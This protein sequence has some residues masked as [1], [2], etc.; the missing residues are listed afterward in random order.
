MRGGGRRAAAAWA[1]AAAAAAAL[2]GGAAA[3]AGGG[4]PQGA[5]M[6]QAEMKDLNA[7]PTAD[8]RAQQ[9]DAF[10]QLLGK[11][12]TTF[13]DPRA[14]GWAAREWDPAAAKFACPEGAE[15]AP[16]LSGVELISLLY[17]DFPGLKGSPVD[18]SIESMTRHLG[19]YE[20]SGHQREETMDML[21]LYSAI[22]HQ[23]GTSGDLP[24]DFAAVKEELFKTTFMTPHKSRQAV[25]A[26]S[27]ALQEY[28]LFAETLRYPGYDW[29]PVPGVFGMRDCHVNETLVQYVPDL[30]ARRGGAVAKRREVV[31][32][33]GEAGGWQIDFTDAADGSMAADASDEGGAAGEEA[34]RQALARRGLGLFDGWR[35]AEDDPKLRTVPLLNVE[36]P[37]RLERSA[38]RWARDLAPGEV[39]RSVAHLRAWEGALGRGLSRVALLEDGVAPLA[40][41]W[42]A[43]SEGLYNLDYLQ[44]EWDVIFLETSDWY[45]DAAN[46]NDELGLPPHFTRVAF[47]YGSRALLVSARGLKRLVEHGFGKCVM[48]TDEYLA[49]MSSPGAHPR[50]SEIQACLGLSNPPS[51]FVALRWRGRKVVDDAEKVLQSQISG[52][53]EAQEAAAG[54]AG[55][56]AAPQK[57]DGEL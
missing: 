21:A 40:G 6:T 11:L 44:V 37:Q 20:G 48:P 26:H 56:E 1:L 49:Y 50:G 13:V 36:M 10:G 46:Q 24:R 41:P 17:S 51:D 47:A 2:A 18:P 38:R 12:E 39:G 31:E 5:P 27:A 54:A 8:Q 35:L 14:A 19:A 45:G 32:A 57:S 55:G 52:F 23:T 16:R 42:C 22:D 29:R 25:E 33:L 3:A 43:L 28:L 7:N 9:Q 53:M 34:A 15:C 4:A 30:A